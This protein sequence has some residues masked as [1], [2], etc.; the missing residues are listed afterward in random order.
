MH[1]P[2]N[3]S[4]SHMSEEKSRPMHEVSISFGIFSEPCFNC[5]LGIFPWVK[6]NGRREVV[7]PKQ[8][9]MRKQMPLELTR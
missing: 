1:A 5:S 9:E 4:C 8:L 6:S 2:I 7:G 3:W